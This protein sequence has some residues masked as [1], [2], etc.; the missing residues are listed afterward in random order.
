M[1]MGLPRESTNDPLPPEEAA[2]PMRGHLSL[3]PDQEAELN[4]N[5]KPEAFFLGNRETKAFP[6]TVCM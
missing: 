3:A 2:Q 6:A 4:S 5:L 1:G